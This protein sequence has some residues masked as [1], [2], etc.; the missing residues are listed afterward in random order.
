MRVKEIMSKPVVCCSTN[1][2]LNEAAQLMWEHDCGVIPVVGDR[3]LLTVFDTRS[4]ATLHD[5]AHVVDGCARLVEWLADGENVVVSS[6]QG[7]AVRRGPRPGVG[8]RGAGSAD[9]RSG[10]TRILPP[11]GDEIVVST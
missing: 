1:S 2:R 4:W 11:A 10:D 6:A 5:S 3:G 8:A 7:V 9:G